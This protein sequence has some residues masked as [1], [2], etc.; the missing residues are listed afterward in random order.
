MS[1]IYSFITADYRDGRVYFEGK[2]YAAGVF[3]VHLLNQF[4]V[5]DTAARLSVFCDNV[6]YNIL[7]QLRYGY[8]TIWEFEKTGENML[9]LIKTLP[10]LKPHHG[11]YLGREDLFY[12]VLLC[13]LA[14]SS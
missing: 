14:T 9:E 5:N 6:H 1:D 11:D 4:Y 2:N 13:I 3:A 12:I 10:D 8:L 7:R